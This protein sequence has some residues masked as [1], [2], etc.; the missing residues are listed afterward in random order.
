VIRKRKKKKKREG[1]KELLRE[2]PQRTLA[3]PEA[4][5]ARLPCTLEVGSIG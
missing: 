3:Q 4:G 5:K 2:S 1:Q